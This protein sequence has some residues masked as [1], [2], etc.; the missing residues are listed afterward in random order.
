MKK[1]AKFIEAHHNCR[2]FLVNIDKVRAVYPDNGRTLIDFNENAGC[3]EVDETYEHMRL[4]IG[5]AQGG[6]PMDKS[7]SY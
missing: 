5:S 2:P 7:K 4:M 6:I 3:I 1:M